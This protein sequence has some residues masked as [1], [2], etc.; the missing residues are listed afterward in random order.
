[1]YLTKTGLF[2][3]VLIKGRGAEIFSKFNPPPFL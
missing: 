3:K 1:V 2:R